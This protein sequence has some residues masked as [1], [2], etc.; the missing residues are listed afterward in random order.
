MFWHCWLGDS[1]GIQAINNWAVGFWHG[2]LRNKF[3]TGY[4]GMS[5]IYPQNCP[6]FD[7]L[8]PSNTPIS[9]PTPSPPQ[10]ASRSNQPSATVHPPDRQTNRSTDGL[11]DRPVRIPTYPLL[12]WQRVMW[13]TT[14]T[15]ASV[16][17]CSGICWYWIYIKNSNIEAFVSFYDPSVH[18]KKLQQQAEH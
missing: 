1:K 12:Y 2:Y 4:N 3:P 11:G 8:H 14:V 5:H 13:L 7:D 9:R 10:T 6:L 18:F 15:S 16:P 17:T